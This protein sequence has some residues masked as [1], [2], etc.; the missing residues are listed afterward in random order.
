MALVAHFIIPILYWTLLVPDLSLFT[1]KRWFV[2][3]SVHVLDF[4]MV[5][6]EFVFSKWR[7]ESRHVLYCYVLAWLYIVFTILYH[8]I[9]NMYER[10]GRPSTLH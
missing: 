4:V 2:G 6:I 7:V 5:I 9:Y 8:S 3:L 10:P 1:S